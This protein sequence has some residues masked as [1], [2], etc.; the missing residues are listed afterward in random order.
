VTEIGRYPRTNAAALLQG[1]R[2]FQAGK[3][4]QLCRSPAA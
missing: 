4:K 3:F 1:N 2:N